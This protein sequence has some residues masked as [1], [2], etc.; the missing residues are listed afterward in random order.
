MPWYENRRG[1]RLWYEDD[2]AGFPV[3]ML[4]GWCMSSAVWKYQRTGLAGSLRILT[5]D[6]RGHG[7]SKELSGYMDFDGF[8]SDLADLLDHLKLSKIVLV[9]WSLGGQIALKAC[10]GLADRLAGLVLVSA[11]PSFTASEDFLYGL[12]SKEVSGMR[13]KVQRNIS[14]ALEGFHTRLFAD[15][16]L[17]GHPSASDIAQLLASI[18]DPETAAALD[19]LDSLARTDLRPQLSSI[20]VPTV[21]MNGDQ[22]RICMPQASDYLTSHI[23]GADHSIFS[24]CGHMPFLT[25]HARFNEELIRFTRSVCA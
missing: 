13:L 18:P 5:P 15:N 25:Y 12:S 23:S 19:A 3:V 9:G 1:E 11:T 24:R 4:H 8:A 6:L 16:E 21:I 7:R 17:D 20:A 22:D 14:R 10:A 2:G